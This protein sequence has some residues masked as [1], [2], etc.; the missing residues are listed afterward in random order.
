[1]MYD[2]T[3]TQWVSF[4]LWDEIF[5][6]KIKKIQE[7]IPYQEPIPVPGSPNE[8]EGVLS[9]RGEIIPVVSGMHVASGQQTTHP[10]QAQNNDEKNGSII[11]LESELGQIGMTI[12]AV[13][14]IIQISPQE[15]NHEEAA[16]SCIT[17]SVLHQENLVILLD[18]DPKN[19]QSQAYA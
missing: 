10:K 6:C 15:I 16:R 14:E 4:S 9:I 7:V 2:D 5:A 19:F 1:M 12:D 11:I 17:G 8:I 3:D 18:V 13:N